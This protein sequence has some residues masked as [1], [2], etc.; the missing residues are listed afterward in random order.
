MKNILRLSP[1]KHTVREW[2]QAKEYTVFVHKV[3]DQ[4][5]IFDV[6]SKRIVYIDV[7]YRNDTPVD[8][9]SCRSN[10]WHIFSEDGYC[11]DT[12]SSLFGN[13]YYQDKPYLGGDRI[14]NSGRHVRGWLAFEIPHEKK[15]H[16]LQFM[17]S[18]LGTKA[19]DIEI[20]NDIE[21]EVSKD[22]SNSQR[23]AQG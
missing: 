18:I 3:V 21:I 4:E 1:K 22:V 6:D 20:G 11:F 12:V 23:P 8:N 14:I 7:E 9:M 5:Y 10:Q 15:V 19:V 13:I 16:Y 17:N 2:I